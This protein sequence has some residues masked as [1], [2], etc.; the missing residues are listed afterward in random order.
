MIRLIKGFSFHYIDDKGNV[1]SKRNNKYIKLKTYI[2]S[3][4]HYENIII[5]ENGVRTHCSVHRLAAEA[6]LPNNENKK[7]INH[8]D[9]NPRN[10]NL[11]NLEWCTRKYNLEQSYSTM[12]PTRNY[13][14]CE[15]FKDGKFIKAFNRIAP[16]AKY[17]A[18]NFGVSETSLCKYHKSKNIT[19]EII[20]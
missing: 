15:L 7:E 19:I 4:G 11:N 12:P 9:N 13:V 2:D 17:A 5:S 14:K 6:F 10:N 1:Y 8:K 16:A 20:S 3:K 18:D